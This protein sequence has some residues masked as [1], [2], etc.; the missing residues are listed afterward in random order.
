MSIDLKGSRVFIS[1]GASGIGRAMVE[2]FVKANARVYTCDVVDDSLEAL[3]AKFPTVTAVNCDCADYE[4]V[5]EMF[6]DVQKTLGGLDV[7]VNNVGI[8]GPTARVEDIELE[9]WQRTLDVN[10]TAHFYCTKLATPMLKANQKGVV[11]NLSSVAGRLGFPLRLPYAASKWAVVGFTKTLAAELGPDNIRSNAILP[12]IVDGERI[13]RV[14][15]AKA[16]AMDISFDE[17]REKLVSGV[18]MRTSVSPYD[19][20]NMALFLSSDLAQKVSGQVISVD[21]DVLSIT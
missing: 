21:G 14:I 7:L 8:A 10:I 1:A 17:M 3:R 13:D 18:A 19:I 6:K 9:D 4:A 20:A 11:I 2:T 12:G 5:A 15:D 16:K